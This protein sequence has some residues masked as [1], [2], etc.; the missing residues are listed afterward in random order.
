MKDLFSD[1][2][3]KAPDSVFRR[4]DSDYYYPTYGD[5]SSV[6]Q[7]APTSG[8][9]Y[10]KVE[11]DRTYGLWGNFKVDYTDT[12]LTHVDRALYGAN[13]NWES[14]AATTFGDKRFRI[15][16]FAAEPGTLAARDEPPGR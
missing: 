11:K 7:D 15:N 1:F 5:D 16:A 12:N 14:D 13:I 10:L 8:K 3:N 6:E 9:F 2:V 4:M